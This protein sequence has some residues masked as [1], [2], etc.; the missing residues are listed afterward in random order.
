MRDTGI[1]DTKRY[2]EGYLKATPNRI[3]SCWFNSSSQLR[4]MFE[5]KGQKEIANTSWKLLGQGYNDMFRQQTWVF[6][7]WLWTAS[8]CVLSTKC[9]WWVRSNS[10]SFKNYLV[11]C[12]QFW[13]LVLSFTGLWIMGSVIC[14]LAKEKSIIFPGIMVTNKW[15]NE[16]KVS[17]MEPGT[18]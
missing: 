1:K 9:S 8:D 14:S 10:E 7:A 6:P 12:V 15:Y 13:I 16:S 2:W 3:S 4:L 18:W 11:I 5:G 17:E